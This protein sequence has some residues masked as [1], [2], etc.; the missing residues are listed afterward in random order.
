LEAQPSHD[1][2]SIKKSQ[3]SSLRKS[4]ATTAAFVPSHWKKRFSGYS[5]PF[6]KKSPADPI[7]LFYLM[8]FPQPI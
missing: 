4:R 1:I 8:R 6:E 5:S 7:G 2:E 3:S